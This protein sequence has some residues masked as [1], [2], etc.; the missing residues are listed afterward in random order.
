MS[1]QQLYGGVEGAEEAL[2]ASWRLLALPGPVAAASYLSSPNA[3]QYRLLV[4]LL[5]DEQSMRLTGVA[6]DELLGLARA[7]LAESV[8]RE[9]AESL[10]DDDDFPLERRMAQ[11]VAWGTCQ[12]WQDTARTEADFLR[13]RAR[14]QLTETGAAINRLVRELE[15][16]RESGSS[17]AV[18]APPILRT[19]LATALAALQNGDPAAAGEALARVQTTL[20]DMARTAASWQ[21]RLAAALGG[22]PDPGKVERVL[23]TI[24]DYVDMWGSGVDVYS[25]EISGLARRLDELGSAEGCDG[26][27]SSVWRSIAFPRVGADAG[28][29]RIAEVVAELRENVTTVLAW[30]A[31]PRAQ[32]RALRLQIRDAV[33]PLLKSH[34][35]LLAVGGAVSRRADLLLL[36]AELEQ[37]SD[38][39]AAWRT[40][41]TA[42]GLYQA[43]HLGLLAPELHNASSVLS[44]EA[45]P[46]PISR[47]LRA[48]GSRALVGRAARMSD[49]SQQRRL[50]RERAAR[51]RA[52]WAE[53][54]ALLVAR[55]GTAIS[56]WGPLR[57]DE[58]ELFLDLVA[59]AR[60]RPADTG[61]VSEG[62]SS[63]GRWRIRLSPVEVPGSAVLRT[64]SG[65]LVLA[66]AVVEVLR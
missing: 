63:D 22:A 17:A 16:G 4:D 18:L 2:A 65:R 20:T 43:R 44:W 54:E 37:A 15:Q 38:D 56:T 49:T 35:T 12:A 42:T 29:E 25:A 39:L 32:A 3:K 46:V 7:R 14:Y 1:E 41:C 45:E 55:S 13:N 66:D 34:R 11:L 40:W 24:I 31:G 57:A 27:E 9:R 26:A 30:F 53:A 60:A 36:A 50:A 5:T 48:Q 21:S 51:E 23:A 61:G 52:R 64:P 10:L 62:V 47:R 33:A 59:S 6:H 8:G 58:A 19:E 28:E